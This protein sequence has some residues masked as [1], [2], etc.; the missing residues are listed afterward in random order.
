[1]INIESPTWLDRL[2]TEII[3]TIFDYL[4]N[5]DIIYTFFNFN[6]RFNNLLIQNQ[7]YLNYLDLPETNLNIWKN[8]LSVMA[9]QVESL[10]I[11]T[12]YLSFPLKY[13][14]NLKS[15]IISTS[16]SFSPEQFKQIFEHEQF[17]YLHSFKVK[18]NNFFSSQSSNKD[19]TEQDYLL[20]K[21]LN[22]KSSLKL[23]QCLL[24]IPSSESFHRTIYGTNLNLHSLKLKL[25]HFQDIFKLIP[26]TPNLKYLNIHTSCCNI[27]PV[28]SIKVINIK[29]KQL[30]LTLGTDYMTGIN[31]NHTTQDIRKINSNHLTDAI[32]QFS[33]SLICL[34]LN[35]V[36]FYDGNI[37]EIPFNTLKLQQILE[38]MIELKQFHL[39]AKLQPGGYEW[40]LDPNSLSRF[41]SQYWF[42]R[43]FSFG[44]HGDSLYTLPFHSDYFH[45]SKQVFNQVKSNNPE[46]L[47]NNYRLWY[48]VKSIDLSI[49]LIND[50]NFLKELRVK[51][52][53]LTFIKFVSYVD[54]Q[55]KRRED[56]YVKVEERQTM[57]I[58]LFNV[59]KIQCPT[60]SLENIKEWLI[61]TLPNLTHLILSSTKLPSIDSQLTEVLNKRIQRLDIDV[62]S[63]LKQLTKTSYI[64]FSNV[65]HINFSL[66]S[67]VKH[68]TWYADIIK[69]LLKNFKNLETLT[70]YCPQQNEDKMNFKKKKNLQK[71][72]ENF[73]MIEI[74]KNYQMKHFC[75]WILFSK[76]K[77]DNVEIPSDTGSSALRKLLSFFY[78]K[79]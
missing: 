33:S 38:S 2:P 58:V 60:G 39:Y 50:L 28:I 7:R 40:L 14:S 18:E 17:T 77:C 6:Q 34:S 61:Y 69:K 8:I 41:K 43:N 25:L 31:H 63:D 65:Q 21:V 71:L 72:I 75:D 29:L 9:S 5:N 15:I 42:D 30:D 57:P 12:I 35:L 46:I 73:D 3:V 16:Y 55:L 32:K 36:T 59:T 10:N 1:M 4:S 78:R 47:E 11:N 74:L 37:D 52:P 26:Y 13:F 19:L 56:Q 48:N 64:Y 49:H 20:A 76:Q 54:Y 79:K 70:I 44:I 45:V 62:Y 53:K 51:M 68:V 22:D 67:N 66:Q 27:D 24:I 23:F